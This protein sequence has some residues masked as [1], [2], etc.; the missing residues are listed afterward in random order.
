MSSSPLLQA[1]FGAERD[2]LSLG[3]AGFLRLLQAT[4]CTVR[5]NGQKENP[6]AIAGGSLVPVC[7]SSRLSV[8]PTSSPAG[9]GE[10]CHRL[11]SLKRRSSLRVTPFLQFFSGDR[12]RSRQSG[13]R[14]ARHLPNTPSWMPA[15]APTLLSASTS[16]A[17]FAFLDLCT[18]QR[19][20]TPPSRPAATEL[21]VFQEGHASRNSPR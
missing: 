9:A 10:P 4:R 11:H 5:G 8:S 18:D 16:V 6:P 1:L 20:R 17:G 3:F 21:T 19:P 2:T 12:R 15:R 7:L 13:R 14:E